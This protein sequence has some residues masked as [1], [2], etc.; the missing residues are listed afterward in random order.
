MSNIDVYLA[1]GEERRKIATIAYLGR[2]ASHTEDFAIFVG[3]TTSF[4]FIAVAKD[5]D[6]EERTFESN[7]VWVEV[8][9]AVIVGPD[10]PVVTPTPAPTQKPA[11]GL[12]EM[13]TNNTFFK[14]I[15]YIIVILIILLAVS[16][17][18]YLVLYFK[19]RKSNKKKK[20][21]GE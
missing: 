9:S 15:V 20:Y 18:T 1:M 3:Q 12:K 5:K 14:T 10:A 4:Q 21:F 13:V 19:E 8:K 7:P 16:G 2:G 6:G 11:E 17:I